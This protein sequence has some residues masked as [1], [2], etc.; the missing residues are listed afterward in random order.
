MFRRKDDPT[1]DDRVRCD[2]ASTAERRGLLAAVEDWRAA[3]PAVAAPGAGSAEDLS[4]TA[5]RQRL[6]LVRS[7]SAGRGL[8]ADRSPGA[9]LGLTANR[10][11][12]A[13]RAVSANQGMG[14]DQ[15]P[16][17]SARYRGDVDSATERL[18]AYKGDLDSATERLPAL[19][20]AFDPDA[21][22]ATPALPAPQDDV[23]CTAERLRL[24]LIA[25]EEEE[26][27]RAAAPATSAAR[28]PATAPAPAPAPAPEDDLSATAERRRLA[29]IVHD[30]RGVARVE[31]HDAP[32]GHKRLTLSID[33]PQPEGKQYGYNPY[34]SQHRGHAPVDSPSPRKRDLRKLSDWMQQVRELEARKL[35]GEKD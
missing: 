31:W 28:A 8:G 1:Q 19:I 6:A 18:P 25:F 15:G 14:A 2:P 33:A 3:G 23:D 12:G 11:L 17:P 20:A 4:A 13:D 22:A 9:D 5:A 32:P 26:K 10:S 34:Q 29:K 24:S 16:R 7:L 21:T 27:A 35:R 30:E